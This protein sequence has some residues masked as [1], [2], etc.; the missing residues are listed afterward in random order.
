M[1][2]D[3]CKDCQKNKKQ[4]ISNKLSQ[5]YTEYKK[6][7]YEYFKIRQVSINSD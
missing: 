4:R 5:K 6:L 1:A 3:Y 2:N 7:N